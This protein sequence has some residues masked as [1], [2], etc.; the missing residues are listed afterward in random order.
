MKQI[1]MVTVLAMG[2]LLTGCG[3]EVQVQLKAQSAMDKVWDDQVRFDVIRSGVP[4]QAAG[5][6]RAHAEEVADAYIM[7]KG[8][9]VRPHLQMAEK[10]EIERA[11]PAD[12]VQTVIA[13]MTKRGFVHDTND[14]QFVIIMDV[15]AF[16]RPY[17]TVGPSATIHHQRM[18]DGGDVRRIPEMQLNTPSTDVYA[19]RTVGVG[20]YV[21]DPVSARGGPLRFNYQAMAV[22]LDEF[23]MAE[24]PAVRLLLKRVIAQ[25][26]QSTKYPEVTTAY[27]PSPV[28]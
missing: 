12:V 22:A 24:A 5:Q 9:G 10:T 15:T 17:T 28:Q 14:P 8:P 26:P 19:V 6:L 4:L 13:H 27:L 23:N 21:F 11:R 3:Q 2:A 20:M 7:A 18:A 25:F 1:M 16:D